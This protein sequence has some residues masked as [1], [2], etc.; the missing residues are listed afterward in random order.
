MD[1]TKADEVPQPPEPATDA[2]AEFRK[3]YPAATQFKGRTIRYAPLTEGQVIALDAL[4]RDD[5]D[6]FT[7]GSVSLILATLEG[8]IGTDQWKH[9]SLDLARKRIEA[10]DVMQLFIKIMD[11]MKRDAQK[12]AAKTP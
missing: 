8:C 5:D 12:K 1:I 4:E 9:I 11:K 3:K 7:M 6:H 10:A 2:E